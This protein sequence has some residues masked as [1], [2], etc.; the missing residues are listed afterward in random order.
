MSEVLTPESRRALTST[1][2]F[3]DDTFTLQVMSKKG[4]RCV[5]VAFETTFDAA[6]VA[7]FLEVVGTL[8]F[9]IA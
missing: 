4:L 9:P 3:G 5:A 6:G 1:F 7:V 2:P 8:S